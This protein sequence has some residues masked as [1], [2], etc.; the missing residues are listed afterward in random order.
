MTA[1]LASRAVARPWRLS[2]EA[3]ALWR[4]FPPRPVPQSWPATRQDRSTITSRM[5]AP[6]FLD[7]N[8]VE[9]CNQNLT[10]SK[11]LDWLE[12]Y[13]GETWRERWR[14]SG[15]GTDGRLDWRP[16]MIGDLRRSE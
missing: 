13:S 10:L 11:V 9:R 4:R 8:R 5:L 2:A 7:H 16:M 6:P 14:A 1:N 3:T 15:A 12:M